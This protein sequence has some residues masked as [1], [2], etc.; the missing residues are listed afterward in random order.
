MTD[1]GDQNQ[2]SCCLLKFLE[3]ARFH[4][5]RAKADM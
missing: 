1:R 4:N 5:Q 3:E 2:D